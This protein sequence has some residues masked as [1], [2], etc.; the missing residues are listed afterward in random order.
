MFKLPKFDTLNKEELI[1]FPEVNAPGVVTVSE[2]KKIYSELGSTGI[3]GETERRPNKWNHAVQES[4]P[5]GIPVSRSFYELEFD[6]DAIDLQFIEATGDEEA[7]WRV[8]HRFTETEYTSNNSTDLQNFKIWEIYNNKWQQEILYKHEEISPLLW[9]RDK[10]TFPASGGSTNPPSAPTCPTS[11]PTAPD[12][13][14]GESQAFGPSLSGTCFR[15]ESIKKPF[16]IIFDVGD[17]LGGFIETDGDISSILLKDENV[18]NS[19]GS[20][21]SKGSIN[22]PIVFTSRYLQIY[23]ENPTRTKP[24]YIRLRRFGIENFRFQ[25]PFETDLDP[26]ISHHDNT[27]LQEERYLPP[28]RKDF[29]DNFWNQGPNR[30]I[31]NY[32]GRVNHPGGVN[33]G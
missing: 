19:S 6:D 32:S 25:I 7:Y 28:T 5:E 16:Y 3:P 31:K 33:I 13:E 2:I 4:T 9:E 12:G 29:P 15:W 23:I 10:N 26:E 8:I 17:S 21:I 11:I 18:I 24:T 20:I 14:T 30:P 22:D 27:T 1:G